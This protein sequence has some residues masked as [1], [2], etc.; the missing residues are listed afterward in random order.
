MGGVAVGWDGLMAVVG[1]FAVSFS[2]VMTRIAGLVLT[3]PVLSSASIQAPAKAGIIGTL[4]LMVTLKLGPVPP[5][6]DDPGGMHG[7]MAFFTVALR[8]LVVG[9]SMGM[10]VT[11]LFGAL[12]FAGQ[13]I[14][15]QMG[16]AIANVVDPVNFVSVGVIGQFFNLLGLLLFIVFDGHILMLK[17]LFDSFDLL[18]LGGADPSWAGVTREIIASSARLFEF[19]LRIGLPAVCVVLLVNVGLAVIARTVPQ[20]NIFVIGFLITISLGTLVLGFAVPSIAEVC[21]LLV[22]EGVMS[23]NKIL[24]MM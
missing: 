6:F 18:P 21:R 7:I 8:E 3:T 16:L 2:L 24:R 23:A 10:T 19:G 17:A 13:V 4:S 15:T 5:I 22:R 12:A 20:V 9:G 1:P 14:G 11:L